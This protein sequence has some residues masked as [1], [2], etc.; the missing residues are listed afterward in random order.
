VA[1]STLAVLVLIGVASMRAVHCVVRR[2]AGSLV[3]W[4]TIVLAAIVSGYGVVLGRFARLNSWEGVTAPRSVLTAIMLVSANGR[5][6]AVGMFFGLL[7]LTVYIA[8]G[9]PALRPT[10]R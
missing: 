9:T 1:A 8:L 5:L 6:L 10:R 4:A 2:R 3:G 7:L